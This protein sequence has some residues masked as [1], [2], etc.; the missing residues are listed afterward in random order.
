MRI[1][2]KIVIFLVLFNG[3]A[4]M[5]Q[6]Y[7]VADH[8]GINA[9]TGNPEELDDAV[10]TSKSIDTGNA[11]G[12]TLLAMY[13]SITDTVEVIVRATQPGASM[14]IKILPPG[15]ASD[16]VTWMFSIAPLLAGL[17]ILAYLR[18]V[19]I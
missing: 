14:L 1:S 8:L 4:G 17:D 12:E 15:V 19:D 9:E 13:N 10:E 18:G 11:I 3:W 7:G 2:V 5:L 6:T 16:F